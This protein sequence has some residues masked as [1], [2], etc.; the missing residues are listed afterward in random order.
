MTPS[1]QS[2]ILSS[3]FKYFQRGKGEP[4]PSSSSSTTSDQP[5]NAKGVRTVDVLDKGSEF[6]EGMVKISCVSGF[7]LGVL[8]RATY[9]D[10]VLF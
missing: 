4:E 9:A 6:E 1:N 3:F 10:N 8:I 5:D 7:L 2:T